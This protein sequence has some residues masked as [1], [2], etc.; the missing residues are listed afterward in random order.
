MVSHFGAGVTV[1]E[2]NVAGRSHD[3]VGESIRRGRAGVVPEGHTA[4]TLG[5][6][7]GRINV[8]D[9][10][11]ATLIREVQIDVYLPRLADGGPEEHACFA[12]FRAHLDTHEALHVANARRAADEMVEV[13]NR[14]RSVE[15]FEAG[16]ADLNARLGAD[17]RDLDERTDHRRRP[18]PR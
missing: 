12:R 3:E 10:G 17:D 11:K 8:D 16:V 2:Y 6:I 15:D 18:N 5:R 13:F 4:F 14:V 7:G 1:R 9:N